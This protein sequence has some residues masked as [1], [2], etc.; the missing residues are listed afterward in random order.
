MES[1]KKIAA[2][3]GTLGLLCAACCALPILA[4]IGITA[5][6]LTTFFAA[7]KFLITAGVLVVGISTV[8]LVRNRSKVCTGGSSCSATCSCKKSSTLTHKR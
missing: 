5:G 2:T 1:N 7:N 6:T 4:A 3:F 8:L